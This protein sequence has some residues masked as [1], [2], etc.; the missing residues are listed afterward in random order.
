MTHI[1]TVISPPF[2]TYGQK[3][4]FL[5]KNLHPLNFGLEWIHGPLNGPDARYQIIALSCGAAFVCLSHELDFMMCVGSLQEP[6]CL[7]N[8]ANRSVRWLSGCSDASGPLK[9]NQEYGDITWGYCFWHNSVHDVTKLITVDCHVD[10]MGWLQTYWSI[11][12]ASSVW[13]SKQ[14]IWSIW[15]EDLLM[16]ALE[17]LVLLPAQV[18]KDLRDGWTLDTA[19]ASMKNPS[20]CIY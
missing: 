15:Q 19:Q 5:V 6:V 10:L 9:D 20:K 7:V 1:Y 17:C 16:K 11:Y 8:T 13:S 14:H 2:K 4:H 12:I 18:K 3:L